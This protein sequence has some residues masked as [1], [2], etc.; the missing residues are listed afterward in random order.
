VSLFTN[1]PVRDHLAM[2]GEMTLR[3]LVHPVGGIKEKVL[4]AHRGGVKTI[5]L[6]FRNRKDMKGEPFI[7]IHFYLM[8][9]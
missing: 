9:I 1:R 4:A 3:G 2:T 8:K 5:I 6:P 7:L